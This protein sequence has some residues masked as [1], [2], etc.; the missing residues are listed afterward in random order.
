MR[1]A[2]V[3]DWLTSYTGAERLLEVALELYPSAPVYTLVYDE[4]VFRGKP[5]SQRQVITSPLFRFQ[6]IARHYRSFLPLMPLAIEQFD[7][8]EYDVVISSSTAVAKG[9]LTRSDQLHVAYINTPIRY[10]WELYHDYLED[11]GLR[12]SG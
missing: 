7:L 6:W 10:A 12:G 1:V 11:A 4:A 2:F 9:V 8:R 3:H 5:L